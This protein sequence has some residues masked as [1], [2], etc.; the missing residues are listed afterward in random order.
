MWVSDTRTMHPT[1]WY[2]HS[3]RTSYS[4]YRRLEIYPDWPI[5]FWMLTMMC[6]DLRDARPHSFSR[7]DV[8]WDVDLW[9]DDD[10]WTYRPPPLWICKYPKDSYFSDQRMSM[11]Q[12]ADYSPDTKWS[13]TDDWS[14]QLGT[15]ISSRT[16]VV[17]STSFNRYRCV[18][19]D[20]YWIWT[21]WIWCVFSNVW[22]E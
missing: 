10:D 1:T 14:D 12:W 5:P 9:S 7:V 11:W 18:S 2:L 13:S 3:P 20:E 6:C 17:F 19:E 21:K 4:S 22:W 15:Y 8:S 16:R